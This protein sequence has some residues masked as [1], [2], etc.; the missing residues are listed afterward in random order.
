M[1][2]VL[3]L[4]CL[5]FRVSRLAIARQSSVVHGVAAARFHNVGPSSSPITA[6]PLWRGG[7]VSVYVAKSRGS[8]CKTHI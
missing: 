2:A 4:L 6:Q 3:S 7:A 1:G 5:V 8:A